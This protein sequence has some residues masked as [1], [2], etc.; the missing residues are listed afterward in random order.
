MNKNQTQSTQLAG[1]TY[2]SN[3]YKR[4]DELSQGLAITHEQAS[5]SLTEG[6]IDGKIENA[7]GKDIDLQ[8]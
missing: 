1:R 5:D 2:E 3:D 4:K 6:T 7:N 8:R